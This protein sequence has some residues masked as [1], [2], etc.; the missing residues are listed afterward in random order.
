MKPQALQALEAL[1]PAGRAITDEGALAEYASDMTENPSATPAA[2]ARPETAE[3]IPD[4]L[5]WAGEHGVAVTPCVAATNVGGLAIPSPGGLV[6]DLRDLNRILAVDP[7]AMYALVEPGVT[8][9]QLR[10]RLDA[11][12]PE[13]EYGYPLAPPYASVAANCLLDGLSNLSLRHGAMGEWVNGIE[14]VLPDGQVVRTGSAAISPVW[15]G[16][17]PLPDL[18]GLFLSWQGTTGVVTRMAVQLWPS[19]PHRR[20]FFLLFADAE[21]VFPF[22]RGLARTGLFD[23]LAA[24]SWPMGRMIHGVYQALERTPGEPEYLLY[25]DY[26]GLTPRLMSAKEEVLQ[27]ALADAR[28]TG[29]AVDGPVDVSALVRINPGLGRFGQFPMTLDFLLDHPG[30]GLTWVGTYGPTSGWLEGARQGAAI[31]EAHGFPPGVLTRAMKEGHFGILRFPILF[32][33]S[34]PA[35]VARVRAANEALLDLALDLGFVMYKAPAWAVGKLRARMHPGFRALQE[36]IKALLDPSGIMNP[37]KW[38]L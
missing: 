31:L 33:R 8:F 23:D 24:L 5:R 28:R 38:G 6:L 13:L 12:H 2:A 19:P 21:T 15:F 16:R 9:G 3:Q 10:E 14:A 34:D 22:A 18:T 35:E 37:G 17:A 20:R 4:I 25:G 27:D 1:L 29:A 11:E 36:R 7:D 26:S 32:N 30:G